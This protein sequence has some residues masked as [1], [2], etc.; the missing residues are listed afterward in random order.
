VVAEIPSDG[1]TG[2]HD[3]KLADNVS[4][5]ENKSS[6]FNSSQ[7]VGVSHA[8]FC[9]KKEQV[10]LEGIRINPKYR[11][12]GIASELINRMIRYGKEMDNNVTE[13]AAITAETNTA[14]RHMLEKNAFQ[15][16][17]Q[18]TYYTVGE[19]NHHQTDMDGST[20][21]KHIFGKKQ[22]NVPNNNNRYCKN[23]NVYFASLGDIG[24]II[25]FLSKSKTFV[26]SGRRYFQSW[27][28]YKL[29][30][31]HSEISEL[32][33]DRMIIVVRT[34]S[35]HEIG[36]LAIINNHVPENHSAGQMQRGGQKQ[37]QST[38]EVDDSSYDDDDDASFQVVYLD[39]PTLAILDILLVFIENWVISSNKFSRIQLF[40]PNQIHH[41]NSD[42]YKIEEVL[43]KFGITKSERFLLY[44]RSL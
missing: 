13:A 37:K 42:S 22:G 15:N 19:E 9:P 2:H 8:Y 26:S 39:A 43:A 4:S 25:T 21:R 16:R 3:P 29:D 12:I 7:V 27:K 44:I 17:A 10:W 32:I 18:W 40:T 38:H 20:I 36:G 33:A 11:R 5:F 23:M 28:W 35:T 34:K 6:Y 14:S 1:D 41:E 24:E 30:L 31:E